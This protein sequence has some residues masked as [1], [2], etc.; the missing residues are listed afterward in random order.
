[1]G[2]VVTIL[3]RKD[4]GPGPGPAPAPGPGPAAAAAH[5]NQKRAGER[6]G[7]AMKK[8]C[9]PAVRLQCLRASLAAQHVAAEVAG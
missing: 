9:D 5:P 3:P 6:R 7:K 4:A 1:M 8:V 2:G